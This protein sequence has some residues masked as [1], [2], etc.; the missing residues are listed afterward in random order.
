LISQYNGHG[1][2]IALEEL[3]Y[4]LMSISMLFIG[5]S[6]SKQ[7]RLPGAIKMILTL[8]FFGTVLSFVFYAI[9][10]GIDRSYR[11]EVATITVNFLTLIIAGVL[12]SIFF[13]KQKACKLQNQTAQVP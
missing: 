13:Y 6:F 7:A 3:G 2:F 11:F 12:L 4:F 9:K 1:V 5:L 10:Y 8:S